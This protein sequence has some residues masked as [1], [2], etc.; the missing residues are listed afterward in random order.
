MEEAGGR[1]G[2]GARER[3]TARNPQAPAR[4]EPSERSRAADKTGRTSEAQ[5]TS[6]GGAFD[7]PPEADPEPTSCDHPPRATGETLY[8]FL[9]DVVK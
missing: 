5:G 6:R 3:A 1:F 9:G 8:F 4:L 7:V 2:S